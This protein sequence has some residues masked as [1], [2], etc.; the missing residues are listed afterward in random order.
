MQPPPTYHFAL[1]SLTPPANHLL[2]LT[3][4]VFEAAA[5]HNDALTVYYEM[6]N[7]YEASERWEPAVALYN[8]MVKKFRDDPKACHA[9]SSVPS[10][11][12]SRDWE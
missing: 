5:A 3:Q 4:T 10:C 1:A 2:S 8:R 6:A 11:C 12:V 9:L 7:I